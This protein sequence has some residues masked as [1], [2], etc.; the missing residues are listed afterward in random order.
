MGYAYDIA[1]H[2]G[3]V[4]ENPGKYI[5]AGYDGHGMPVIFLATKGLADMILT[6]RSFEDTNIPKVFKTTS[7]RLEKAANGP[8]GGDIFA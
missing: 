8:E 1:P 2:V 4:P 3:E 5:C 6:G 7:E